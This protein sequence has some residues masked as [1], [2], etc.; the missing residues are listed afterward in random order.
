MS[1]KWDLPFR[2]PDICP[3]RATAATHLI[4]LDLITVITFSKQYKL[5]DTSLLIV[6]QPAVVY[7]SVSS[8]ILFIPIR[9]QQGKL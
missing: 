5:R 6:L 9:K 2:F 8:I 1:R 4:F 3:L 7:S